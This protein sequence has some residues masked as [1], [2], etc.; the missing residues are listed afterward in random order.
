MRYAMNMT[1]NNPATP[2]L[3]FVTDVGAP[4]MPAGRWLSS[5]LPCDGVRGRRRAPSSSPDVRNTGDGELEGKRIR[6]RRVTRE[7][8][9]ELVHACLGEDDEHAFRRL[10]D[11]YRAA[12]HG[13]CLRVTGNFQDAEDAAQDTFLVVHEK[14]STFR[15]Q[16]R[17]S[18]WIFRVAYNKGV[19][20]RRS[21]RRTH[22]RR[23]GFDAT[24][25]VDDLESIVDHR[26]RAIP[27]DLCER[28]SC[29]RIEAAVHGLSP[30]LRKA[31]ALRYLAQLSYKE[32][33]ERLAI[34]IGTVRSRLSRA[35]ESVRIA[36][37]S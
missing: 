22:P 21:R 16:S 2:S 17:F 33:G 5:N 20:I 25:P 28:E 9:E 32:I 34:P 35:R 1:E 31:A 19:E 24:D 29:E 13:I 10:H 27:E 26:W 37:A 6:R 14:L 30:R 3:S 8:Q 7:S 12:I 11:R 15:F 4:S 23:R 18:S 36:K